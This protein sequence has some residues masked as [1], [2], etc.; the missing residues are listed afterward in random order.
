MDPFKPYCSRKY[1][2][3]PC[4]HFEEICFSKVKAAYGTNMFIF[5]GVGALTETI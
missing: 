3:T 2:D 1:A 5:Q 4:F